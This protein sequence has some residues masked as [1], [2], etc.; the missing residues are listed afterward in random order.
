MTEVDSL[1]WTGFQM[2]E[3]ATLVVGRR[4]LLLLPPPNPGRAMLPPISLFPSDPEPM[5]ELTDPDSE[6]A[7][8]PKRSE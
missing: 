2:D 4:Q 5:F 7:R 1:E 3:A 6:T 8:P